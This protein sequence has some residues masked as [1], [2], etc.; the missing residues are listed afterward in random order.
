MIGGYTNNKSNSKT[1]AKLDSISYEWS[2]AGDLIQARHG[3]NAIFDKLDI[4]V[5]GGYVRDGISLKTEK[6]EINGD[7]VTCVEQDPALEHYSYYP[8][9]F[10]VEEGYC[11]ERPSL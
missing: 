8:E 6:C 4:I 9:L 2:K 1:I 11:K 5:V 3:H 10:L 7:K